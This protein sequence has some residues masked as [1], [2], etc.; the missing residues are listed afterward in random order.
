MSYLTIPT[1]PGDVQKGNIGTRFIA[2]IID[3]TTKAPKPINGTSSIEFHF[4]KP[5]GITVI[6]K[7]AQFLTDGTDG[8]MYY[9][10]TSAEDLDT[11][12][13]WRIQAYLESPDGKVLRS[14]VKRFVVL[15]NV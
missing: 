7:T 9:E 3:E 2:R 13:V 8:L 12:G 15:D 5:G 6:E 10:T 4:R 14:K 11:V 1:I